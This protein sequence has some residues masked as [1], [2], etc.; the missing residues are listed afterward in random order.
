MQMTA[1]TPG[2]ARRLFISYARADRERVQQLRKGLERLHYE[3]WVDDRRSIGQE[4]WS[5]ILQ[6]IRL[7]DALVVAVSPALEESQ[8]S[9][10]EQDYARALGKVFLPVLLRPVR[11]GSLPPDLTRLQPVDYGEPGIDAASELVEAL[12][13]LPAPSAL[14]EPLPPDPEVPVSYVTV[15]VVKPMSVERDRNSASSKPAGKPITFTGGDH[16]ELASR[17]HPPKAE[18]PASRSTRSRGLRRRWSWPLRRTKVVI[19]DGEDTLGISKVEDEECLRKMP[20]RGIPAATTPPA[21]PLIQCEPVFESDDGAIRLQVAP[22]YPLIQCE[23]VWVAYEEHLV[24]IGLTDRQLGSLS[25]TGP[26][27]GADETEPIND[28]TVSLLLDPASI[29]L[30]DG[31]PRTYPLRV[32]P[33]QRF[34]TVEVTMTA[35]SG[36]HL[37]R[38]RRIGLHFMR[39]GRSVGFAW[40]R[41][42]VV[43]SEAER[44]YAQ[45]PEPPQ[46][47][48]DLAAVTDQQPPDLVLALYRGDDRSARAYVWDALATSDVIDVPDTQRSTTLQDDAGA[49]FAARVRRIVKNDFAPKPMF[50]E[51]TGFGEEIGRVIPAGIADVLR[52]LAADGSGGVAASVLLVTEEAF[53]PWELAV[54]PG[55]PIGQTYGG[56]SPFLG[57][58]IAISRWPLVQGRPRPTPQRT[59]I[60]TRQAV[61]SAKYDGVANWPKLPM[62]EAEAEGVSA[63]YPPMATIA[64]VWDAVKGCL[65]GNP[66]VDWLHVALHGQ[67]DPEGADDGLVLLQGVPPHLAQQ[68]LTPRQVTSFRMPLRPFVFL[69]A[70]QVGAGNQELGSYAG[71]AVALLQAGACAVVA[72]QWNVDDAVA[73]EV[74]N[75]F[76]TD[77]FSDPPVPVAEA[78]RR[79]RASYTEDKVDSDPAHTHPTLLAYQLFGHPRL[80]LERHPEPI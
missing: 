12:N 65:E 14:P 2:P 31:M 76:Y 3:V 74:T 70:C 29:Q 18:P 50:A 6:Q 37:D 60:I 43:D 16:A 45:P 10:A 11:P 56:S 77:V 79:I 58:H 33:Q 41:V 35:V 73:A 23:P 80:V 19:S 13:K 69:N 44:A 20:I 40:R 78:L 9:N 4:W 64:P 30:A 21:D 27:I 48:L 75:R 68:F 1:D 53:V 54:L 7:C 71:M 59:H 52:T 32:T 5:E 67:F 47:I 63:Q 39:G 22:A 51:L 17:S 34:P 55:A 8:Q 57:A 15:P 24:V 38:Q 62:A 42:V 72:A 66:P 61:L 28:L 36:G 49:S 25:S 46:D 26:V